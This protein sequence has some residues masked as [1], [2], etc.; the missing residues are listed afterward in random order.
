MTHN[1]K[2]VKILT[3]SKSK[4]CIAKIQRN[5]TLN[6]HKHRLNVCFYVY[7]DCVRTFTTIIT[8]FYPLANFTLALEI[9]QLM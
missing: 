3:I 2:Y 8:Y 4:R 7:C 5:Q 6:K 9:K 1:V